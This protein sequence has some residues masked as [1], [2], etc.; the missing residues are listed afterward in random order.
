MENNE[1]NIYEA[2]NTPQYGEI[3]DLDQQVWAISGQILVTV[4]RSNAV[5]PVTV[6][7]L[8]CKYPES[9]EQGKGIPIYFG[10]RNPEKC[11]FCGE[12]DGQPTLQLKEEKILDL[13]N[14]PEPQKPFLFY[15]ART[16]RTSTF[17]SVAFPGMFIASSKNNE[18]IFLTS[19]QGEYYNINFNLNV[20]P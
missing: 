11:L 18:P 14:H 2:R 9:L 20:G 16:G 7:V 12:V 1:E 4:P 10:I 8:A 13:Y 6:T 15:H 5:D 3:S 17:E 19:K